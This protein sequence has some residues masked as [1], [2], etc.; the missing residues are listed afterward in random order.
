MTNAIPRDR[1]VAVCGI[2]AE[3]NVAFFEKR[4]DVDPIGI[5][6]GSHDDSGTG[7]HAAQAA[8]AGPAKQP[9]EKRFRLIVPGM[10]HGNGRGVCKSG[11][12]REELVA[13]VMR[14]VFGGD[15]GRPGER[16]NV[17]TFDVQRNV[18]GG[19]DTPAEFFVGVCIGAAELMIQV[20]RANEVKTFDRRDL[21][22]RV[23]QRDRIGA[24]RQGDNHARPLWEEPMAPD[25]STNG[26][27][28]GWHGLTLRGAR[29]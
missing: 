20:D 11:G 24:A 10:R 9:Q 27:E 2:F 22:Q 14:R 8:R 7:M 5:E 17:N 12:A 6:E 13:R 19:S 16:R 28:Q 18:E 3:C 25:R 4:T 26:V 23:E 15:T 21:P 1:S 29:D